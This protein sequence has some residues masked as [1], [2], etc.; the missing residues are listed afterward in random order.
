MEE[1][2]APAVLRTQYKIRDPKGTRRW[3]RDSE[4][5]TN[6]AATAQR[7]RRRSIMDSRRQAHKVQNLSPSQRPTHGI[8]FEEIKLTEMQKAIITEYE[9]DAP[10]TYGPWAELKDKHVKLLKQPKTVTDSIHARVV[11]TSP[12]P[13][14]YPASNREGVSAEIKTLYDRYDEIGAYMDAFKTPYNRRFFISHMTLDDYYIIG[15]EQLDDG[16]P[17]VLFLPYR[18]LSYYYTSDDK[19]AYAINVTPGETLTNVSIIR[20]PF[21]FDSS[22]R[23]SYQLRMFI[24]EALRYYGCVEYPNG[25]ITPSG[26]RIYKYD[27]YDPYY[28]QQSHHASRDDGRPIAAEIAFYKL[29]PTVKE[30]IKQDNARER[31]EV[32]RAI[33]TLNDSAHRGSGGYRHFGR[34]KSTKPRKSMKHSSK[35][36]SRRTHKKH[37]TRRRHRKHRTTHRK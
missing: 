35:K 17:Q 28:F 20:H 13:S 36:A 2:I 33:T 31:D 3:L 11:N 32:V 18:R 9:E 6:D 12:A 29:L 21:V 34:S 24:Y 7:E 15:L 37:T 25:F 16:R 30:Q 27:Q 5:R 22:S 1:N 23:D 19:Y 8:S 14:P 26:L 4:P 10:T